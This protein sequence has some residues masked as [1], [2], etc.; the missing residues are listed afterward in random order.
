MPVP[1]SGTSYPSN[2]RLTVPAYTEDQWVAYA[3]TAK[4]RPPMPYWALH[5]TTE[6]DLRAMYEFIRH[7]GPAGKPAP[8]FLPPDVEPPLPYEIRRV[9]TQ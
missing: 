7:L 3:R 6:Q 5:Q 2:L 4:M 9:V 8:A 1:F